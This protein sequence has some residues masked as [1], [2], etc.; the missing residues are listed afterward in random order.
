MKWPLY[1]E[2][3]Y[4][5]HYLTPTPP[6]GFEVVMPYYVFSIYFLLVVGIIRNVFYTPIKLL[7]K[8][9]EN[10]WNQYNTGGI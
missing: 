5:L 10:F 8:K 2:V 3:E 1:E 6:Q 9:K 7:R 4:F